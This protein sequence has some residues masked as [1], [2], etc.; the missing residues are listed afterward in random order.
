M[1]KFHIGILA[2]ICHVNKEC[3]LNFL[4]ACFIIWSE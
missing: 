2:I 1:I 4:F 3:F